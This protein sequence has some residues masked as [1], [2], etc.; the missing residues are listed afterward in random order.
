MPQTTSPALR[1]LKQNVPGIE[2][3]ENTSATRDGGLFGEDVVRPMKSLV[4]DEQKHQVL[5]P[6]FVQARGP[7]APSQTAKDPGPTIAADGREATPVPAG[8]F[9]IRVEGNA[10]PASPNGGQVLKQPV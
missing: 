1:F 8:L 4:Y 6:A 9:Q 10:S 5:P 2:I 3:L 7:V